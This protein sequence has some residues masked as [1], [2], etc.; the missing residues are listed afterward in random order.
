MSLTFSK[1]AGEPTLRPHA[2]PD[3]PCAL[4]RLL[5]DAPARAQ[6]PWPDGFEG[7]IAHRLDVSTSGALW[8]ADDPAELRAMRAA[9]SDGRLVKTYVFRAARDVPWDDHVCDRPVAHDRRRRR[10]MIVRR[11]ADTPH[12]GRWLPAA[13]RFTRLEGDLWR[14]VIRTGVMHQ[15]RVHAAFVGLRLAGD[16]VYGGGAPPEDAPAGASFLLHHVGL[17]GPGG[18]GTE[19]VPRPR[20]CGPA[21][22]PVPWS[23]ATGG[24]PPT[25][26]R[27]R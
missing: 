8:V 17:R 11:G 22:A 1:R 15:I 5:A 2:D 9:F 3:G 27:G 12:R 18:L 7:G 19:P 10:R 16:A 21:I 14:A 24:G 26:G 6:V 23:P 20:W 13:T 4:R 25:P